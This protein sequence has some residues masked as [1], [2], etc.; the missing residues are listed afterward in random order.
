VQALREI[1]AGEEGIRSS[2]K[3]GC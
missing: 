1:L 3:N 2:L